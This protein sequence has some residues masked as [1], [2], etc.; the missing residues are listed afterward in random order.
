[1]LNLSACL[2]ALETAD[3]VG[4]KSVDVL[5]AEIIDVAWRGQTD[6]RGEG[7]E[8]DREIEVAVE[9]AMDQPRDKRVPGTEAVNDLDPIARSIAELAAGQ[10]KRAGL[11]LGRTRQRNE[12]NTVARGDRHGELL[13]RIAEPSTPCASRSVRTSRCK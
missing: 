1:M 9:Q 13:P 3:G 12:R 2:L 4:A 5:R 7:S 10:Q 6:C 11:G 8:A